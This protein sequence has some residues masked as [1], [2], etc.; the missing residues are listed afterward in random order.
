MEE[1]IG[2]VKRRWVDRIMSLPGVMKAT[3]MAVRSVANGRWYVACDRVDGQLN[4]SGPVVCWTTSFEIPD[5]VS[6]ENLLG[7][8]DARADR[9][10]AM[11]TKS[12]LTDTADISHFC[13]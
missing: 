8:L 6:P 1:L 2:L 4:G 5:Q 3:V 11:W 10:L 9:A 7:V 12:S 13:I